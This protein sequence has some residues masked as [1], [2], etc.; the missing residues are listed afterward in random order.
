MIH[1]PYGRVERTGEDIEIQAQEIVRSA[2]GTRRSWPITRASRSR[3]C[4]RTRIAT[5][6]SPQQAKNYG[7]VD[8]VVTDRKLRV[9]A[10]T[11]VNA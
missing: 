7:L 10:A 5:T 1:Q 11:A 3:R 9:A 2:G 4:A 6:C 8:E